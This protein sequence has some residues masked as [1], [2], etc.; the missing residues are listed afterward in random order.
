MQ[1]V[2]R[3]FF[4]FRNF[5]K[6]LSLQPVVSYRDMYKRR[7]LHSNSWVKSRSSQLK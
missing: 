6:L 3:D 2:K 4:Y 7:S 5:E 1:Y